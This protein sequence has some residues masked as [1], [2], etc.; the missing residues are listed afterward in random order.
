MVGRLAGL[1]DHLRDRLLGVE[2]RVLRVQ[3]R[4]L[5]DRRVLDPCADVRVLEGDAVVRDEHDVVRRADLRELPRGLLRRDDPRHR[6]APLHVDALEV[7]VGAHGGLR[8][9]HGGRGV[10]LRRVLR[11]LQPRVLLLD[12]VDERNAAVAS[13]DRRE[14]ALEHG[15]VAG[16]RRVLPDVVARLRAVQVVVGPDDH[17]DLAGGRADVDAHD[18][19]VLAGR[20]V[21]RG[22]DRRAVDRVDDQ[23][24]H[25]LRDQRPDLGRLLRRVAVGRHR[26]D[27]RDAVL[28]GELLLVRDVRAPEVG[29]VAREGDTDLDPGGLLGV[30]AGG[31][32]RGRG[33][34][35]HEPEHDECADQ[36]T[37]FHASSSSTFSVALFHHTAPS[38]NAYS[39]S[40]SGRISML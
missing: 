28:L 33:Q 39:A 29:A 19:D 18:R 25:A 13:V 15:D 8:V 12:A 10:P 14:V 1:V 16:A 22:R 3:V 30:S 9:V 24:L 36:A 11:D 17:V 2:D 23:R 27:E 26:A 40:V 37:S 35:S 31:G 5:R 6:A 20:V 32:E 7:A 4:G 38:G 21:E 34:G